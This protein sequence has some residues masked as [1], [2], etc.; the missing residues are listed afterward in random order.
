MKNDTFREKICLGH[1]IFPVTTWI[2]HH[3]DVNTWMG[4]THGTVQRQQMDNKSDRVTTT[5]KDKTEGRA[6]NKMEGHFKL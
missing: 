2:R 5:R 6:K 4:G 3:T 1:Y